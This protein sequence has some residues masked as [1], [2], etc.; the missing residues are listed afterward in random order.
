MI[1]LQTIDKNDM[2]K[3]QVSIEDVIS[4]FGEMEFEIY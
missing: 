4:V 2:S 3:G 1:E